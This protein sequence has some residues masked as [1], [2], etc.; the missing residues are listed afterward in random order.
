[1][2]SRRP[3][4]FRRPGFTLIEV[5]AVALL[6]AILAGAVAWSFS[7]PVASVRTA[8]VLD[9][10]KT[11]DGTAR[12]AARNT[13]RPV[14]MQFD[15][16]EGSMTRFDDRGQG[17]PFLAYRGV[18]P[19]GYRI[20]RVRLPDSPATAGEG[21]TTVPCSIDG[22][23]PTYAVCLSGGGKE[24]WL[25]FAGLTGQVTEVNDESAVDAIFETVRTG[26]RR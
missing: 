15:P 16:Y 26:P 19:S 4:N 24:H 20:E 13:G 11:F 10:I 14:T 6:M 12:L 18:L 25:L 9:R 21:R 3:S 17:E 8:D 23:T 22:R 2:P 5:A 7:G 1:M